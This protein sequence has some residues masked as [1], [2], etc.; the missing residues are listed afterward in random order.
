MLL[1]TDP[2]PPQWIKGGRVKKF[3]QKPDL[4]RYS[5]QRMKPVD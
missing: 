5:S 3:N 1:L 4:Q 2:R